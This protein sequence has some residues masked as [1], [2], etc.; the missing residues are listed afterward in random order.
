MTA[1]DQ[2]PAH[3][4]Y[5]REWRERSG[6]T[7]TAI[8]LRLGTTHAT[9]SRWERGHQGM[10]VEHLVATAEALGVKPGDLFRHPDAEIAPADQ[11]AAHDLLRLRR[12]LE[13]TRADR[14]RLEEKVAI[15]SKTVLA[16]SKAK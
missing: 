1:N 9:V 16:L 8:A 2:Q 11:D 3:A 13:D 7:Q 15:L 4:L 12:E 14:D 6:M 10:S 5:L